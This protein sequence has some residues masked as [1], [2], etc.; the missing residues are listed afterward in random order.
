MR[1]MQ[2]RRRFDL[3]LVVEYVIPVIAAWVSRR[4]AAT[5]IVA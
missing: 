1:L 4:P 5:Y 2:Y 3:I